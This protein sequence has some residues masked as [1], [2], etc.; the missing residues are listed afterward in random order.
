MT[1]DEMRLARAERE[2]KLY[3]EREERVECWRC[4]L[5]FLDGRICSSSGFSLTCAEPDPPRGNGGAT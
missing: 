3:A 1:R 5:P 4:G 2:Q